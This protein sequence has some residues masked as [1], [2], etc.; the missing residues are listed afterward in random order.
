MAT[1]INGSG[2]R[3]YFPDAEQNSANASSQAT[4]SLD[5]T[6]ATQPDAETEQTVPENNDTHHTAIEPQ[7]GGTVVL[8]TPSWR[9]DG[10]TTMQ[11]TSG[12][13]VFEIDKHSLMNH[14]TSLSIPP[15]ETAQ[16]SEPDQEPNI[17]SYVD[18]RRRSSQ[19]AEGPY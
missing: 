6:S 15:A 1:N 14:R 9:P 7:N 8:K 19:L 16:L 11:D 4:A 2:F 13:T 18:S 3:L 5:H 10:S 17:R 12:D